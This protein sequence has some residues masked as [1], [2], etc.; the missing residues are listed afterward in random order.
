MLRR[1]FLATASATA[2]TLALPARAAASGRFVAADGQFLLD[3][4][5]FTIRAGELHYPRIPRAAWRDRLR[6]ARA[7]GLN[8]ITTYVFWSQH[9]AE[10]GRFD[11]NGQ[12]DLRAF[13]ATAAEEGLHVVL[14]PGPYVCAEVDFGGFPAWL[15]RTP[16]LRVR[17]LDPRYLAASARYL[18][19]L[20]Q[21]IGDL[22]SSRG[23]PIL[24]LQ[25]ENEYGSF[26]RDRDYL[27]AT[28]RQLRDAGFDLPLFTSD[29]GSERLLAAGS[30]PGVTAVV[31][32]GGG[33]EDAHETL[34]ALQAWRPQGP[35][36]IGEYWAG[37]FDH[38]GEQHHRQPPGE[39]GA[40]VEAL[41][42]AGAS[43]NLYM[44]HGG[45]SFGWLPGANYGADQ[46]YQPDTTSY[47]YDAAL[48]E[49]GRVTPK[50]H[51]LRAVIARHLGPG[52]RLPDIPASAP[53]RALP[54]FELDEALALRDALP[55]LSAP[56]QSR[57]PANMEAFGQ[58][59]GYI[60]YRKRLAQPAKGRLAVNE[61]RDHALLL[62]DGREIG[63][64]D[65]RHAQTQLDIDLPAGTELD[66]LVENMG[67]I[68]FG[69]KLDG[70]RKGIT[71]SVELE[72]QELLD[73]TVFPLEL[74]GERVAGLR[75][76]RT[77]HAGPGFWRGRLL[78]DQPV[79]D[80][81]L[82]LRGWGKGQVWVN[83]HHLGR[84]W[85]IGPQQTLYLPASW[86]R[87]GA[88]EVIVFTLAAPARRQMRALAEPVYE[89]PPAPVRGPGGG[90]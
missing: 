66:I 30:V 32:F 71:Q 43:F 7:M 5:P 10:P 12:R 35:R 58:N 49:A 40:T 86:L 29:G 54:A 70:E 62:A 68:G 53:P 38:W 4:Q 36:M 17:S 83:G 1:T 22:Q 9:E 3:G 64:L 18:A 67:R 84:F 90:N 73:W 11:F 50:Y 59:Y 46:P 44:F 16:G 34:A 63:Q 75:F 33:V 28:Q 47:D 56:R 45:T 23:G 76:G 42:A 74:E 57:F 21:E 72:Q 24:M 82:D 19:R 85:Q 61:V 41:L 89:T 77:A 87:A 13:I 52:E 8:A 48:D 6:K 2:L 88:N 31:N 80:T 81:F 14:R 60:L 26:G 27:A 15:L 25:L 39:A 51:E 79:A 65:R 37:W 69:A 78:V 20:G 55:L